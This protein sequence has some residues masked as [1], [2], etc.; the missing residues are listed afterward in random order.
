MAP[1]GQS[2][3]QPSSDEAAETRAVLVA[4]RANMAQA[5]LKLGKHERALAECNAVL[6]VEP[7][8]QKALY[9][10]SQAHLA[11]KNY[12]AAKRDLEQL[13]KEYGDGDA[14]VARSLRVIAQWEKAQEEKEKRVYAN[15]F[16]K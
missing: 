1:R 16:A 8:H 7:K 5:L 13:Q 3:S 2:T 9:R 10:R 4:V 12:D 15:M 14:N 11:L 6:L